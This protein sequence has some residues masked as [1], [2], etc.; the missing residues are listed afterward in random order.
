MCGE[1]RIS[2][3]H[4]NCLFKLDEY[5]VLF[6]TGDSERSMKLPISF[7][8]DRFTTAIPKSQ[9]GM[10]EYNTCSCTAYSL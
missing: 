4:G 2:N 5:F 9:S 6:C 3:M 7:L 10:L 8:C 1:E